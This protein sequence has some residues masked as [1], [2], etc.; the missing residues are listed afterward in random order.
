MKLPGASPNY[1]ITNWDFI[2]HLPGPRALPFESQPDGSGAP[3]TSLE[4][5]SVC[6]SNA[7]AT[8]S[9]PL[10]GQ[11]NT[12]GGRSLTP[13][14][15]TGMWPEDYWNVLDNNTTV[16]DFPDSDARRGEVGEIRHPNKQLLSDGEYP[17]A[18]G[19]DLQTPSA[20][21]SILRQGGPIAP[22]AHVFSKDL[23][24]RVR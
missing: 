5:S 16:E 10:G 11:W 3:L 14:S 13:G 18:L 21:T 8:M 1:S 12:Y 6:G 20:N 22:S 23:G 15:N 9:K 24:R 4:N 7:T 17:L 2:E 19:R